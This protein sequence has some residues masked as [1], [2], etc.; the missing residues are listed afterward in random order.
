MSE[1][2]LTITM[3]GAWIPVSRVLWTD[4]VLMRWSLYRGLASTV[5]PVA[6]QVADRKLLLQEGFGEGHV[7]PRTRLPV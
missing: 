4:A 2:T 3:Y 5:Y 1:P 7:G 6:E